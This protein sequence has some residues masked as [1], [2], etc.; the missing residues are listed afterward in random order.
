MMNLF[1]SDE[2]LDILAY[3]LETYPNLH[4]DLGGRFGE[5]GAMKRDH[6]REFVIRYSDRILFGTDVTGPL[7][8]RDT[9]QH[10]RR[11]RP[12]FQAAGNR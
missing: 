6:L 7:M 3:V 11:I 1:R 12:G 9:K 10:G 4:V 8:L 2:Q 5:F